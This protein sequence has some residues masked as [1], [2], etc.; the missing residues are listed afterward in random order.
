MTLYHSPDLIQV[1][2]VNL[3]SRNLLS[4]TLA[5]FYVSMYVTAQATTQTDNFQIIAGLIAVTWEMQR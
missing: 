5:D 3:D 1:T 2:E 4:R